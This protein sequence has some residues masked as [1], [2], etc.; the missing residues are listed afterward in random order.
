MARNTEC[1]KKPKLGRK[2][3]F[4]T[5]NAPCSVIV[6]DESKDLAFKTWKHDKE[7]EFA[8]KMADTLDALSLGG[9]YYTFGL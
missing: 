8:D 6:Y 3:A 2:T 1:G 9:A 5:K 4:I 7:Q